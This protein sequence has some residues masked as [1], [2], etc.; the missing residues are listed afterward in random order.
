MPEQQ[1]DVDSLTVK[2]GKPKRGRKPKA[3]KEV[4]ATP[5]EAPKKRGRKPG[6][7]SAKAVLVEAVQG[8]RGGNIVLVHFDGKNVG[9]VTNMPHLTR[10]ELADVED[11]VGAGAIK[12]KQLMKEAPKATAFF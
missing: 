5:A 9:L 12:A 1:I 7:K 4:K 8:Y 11:V 2:S 6:S 3:T 10:D